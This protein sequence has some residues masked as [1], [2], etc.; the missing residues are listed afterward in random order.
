LALFAA[1]IAFLAL[2]LASYTE[3]GTWIAC[4]S[5]VI[6][7][8][9]LLGLTFLSATLEDPSQVRARFARL[10]SQLPPV[11]DRQ[12]LDELTAAAERVS[13][14]WPCR[15]KERPGCPAVAS[16][17]SQDG[18]VPRSA[19]SPSLTRHA[20]Q[21]ASTVGWPEAKQA[22][23]ATSRAPVKWLLDEQS[24]PG[25]PGH[26]DAFLIGGINVSDQPL[27]DVK[28]ILKPDS[29]GREL[30]LALTVEGRQGEGEA[31]IPPGARFSLAHDN[32]KEDNPDASP[33]E[34]GGGAILTFR[35]S[36]AGRQKSTILYLTPTMVSRLA[37]RG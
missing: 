6:S 16:R 21:A 26:A 24:G 34:Q 10:A 19:V 13:T 15:A 31:V 2:L 4:G 11:L 25:S 30:A 12:T 9:A 18:G 3:R 33:A 35:Y 7:L 23:K 17:A 32:P 27:Q 1:G 36:Q 14:S 28:A 8:A 37:N 20:M 22:P 29:S 5:A